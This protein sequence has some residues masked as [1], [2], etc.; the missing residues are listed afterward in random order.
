MYLFGY[1]VA[2]YNSKT[3]NWLAFMWTTL[4]V[5]RPNETYILDSKHVHLSLHVILI[6]QCVPQMKMNVVSFKNYIPDREIQ[7]TKYFLS[8]S[9]HR[10]HTFF[11]NLVLT[12]MCMHIKQTWNN[13]LIQQPT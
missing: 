10:S 12:E 8:K 9:T 11:P 5:K 3:N 2:Y 13:C 7:M 4:C 1:M 6:F